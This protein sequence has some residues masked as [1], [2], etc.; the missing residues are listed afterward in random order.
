MFI[1]SQACVY[2]LSK[3]ICL[4]TFILLDS[5]NGWEAQSRDEEFYRDDI[6]TE[7]NVIFRK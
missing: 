2:N 6:G 3:G 5:Q 4:V 7:A 1:I